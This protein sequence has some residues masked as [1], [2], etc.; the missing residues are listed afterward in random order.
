[1]L[2]QRALRLR[3][4]PA[5][6]ASKVTRD[7]DREIVPKLGREQGEQPSPS[8][9]STQEG[10]MSSITSPGPGAER[11]TRL[12]ELRIETAPANRPAKA[13]AAGLAT[14]R[15]ARR[16][17]AELHQRIPPR[18]GRMVASKWGDG[19]WR[20]LARR[21]PYAVTALASGG[22]HSRSVWA[23]S[24]PWSHWATGLGFRLQLA[25]NERDGQ[26]TQDKEGKPEEQQIASS[27][28]EVGGDLRPSAAQQQPSH[29]CVECS[30]EGSKGR[31]E[32]E[33][34]GRRGQAEARYEVETD[35]EGQ[36]RA[37][38][39]RELQGPLFA[40][41]RNS[42]DCPC[43]AMERLGAGKCNAKGKKLQDG[44]DRHGLRGL[45]FELGRRGP[46][47]R[48]TCAVHD[49][50]ERLARQVACR[51]R[52]PQAKTWASPSSQRLSS[53]LALNF[54]DDTCPQRDD[55]QS[56]WIP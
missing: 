44:V 30:H 45:T 6:R 5:V 22:S 21:T 4:Q 56:L 20:N 23:G 34:P 52:S 28:I 24:R 33:V 9:T 54:S 7:R 36:C 17:P 48:W 1:M 2:A 38:N 10:T 37:R 25:P 13:S 50:S 49:D 15:T 16:R 3:I 43:D 42:E 12:I 18:V 27:G 39:D 41:A 26:R 53:D 47:R 51:W 55:G 46:G 8:G 19:S 11:A 14:T 32:T 31:A 35:A 29:R 40:N